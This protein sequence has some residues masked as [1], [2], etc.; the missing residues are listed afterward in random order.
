MP[1]F[2]EI[3]SI[4]VRLVVCGACVLI[5]SRPALADMAFRVSEDIVEDEVSPQHARHVTHWRGTMYVTDTDVTE[6]GWSTPRQNAR[7]VPFDQPTAE[8]SPGGSASV[9]T[10]SKIANGIRIVREYDTFIQTRRLVQ[11]G[12]Q[13]CTSSAVAELKPGHMFFEVHR[14]SNH[15]LMQNTRRYY[16]NQHCGVPKLVG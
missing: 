8:I 1:K 6:T 16:I 9:V 13:A 14:V 7:V 4:A 11:T 2:D 5:A 10:I 15:E 12:P 3:N